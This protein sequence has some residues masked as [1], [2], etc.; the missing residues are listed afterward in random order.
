MNFMNAIDIGAS[1]LSAQR[2]HLNVVS[3]NLA[4]ASTTRTVTGG[5]Y[6][7]KVVTMKAAELTPFSSVMGTRLERELRGV[8]VNAVVN[9][10]GPLRKVYDPTH[11]D[12]DKS[13]YVSYP[14]INAVQEMANLMS[15]LRIY[16]ANV[17]S[18]ST[19]KNM[20]NKATEI[21]RG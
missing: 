18:I 1:G 14:N 11:P 6:H 5:P 20:F 15:V 12:A 7:K 3:M 9:D 10:P 16:E 21:G 19:A 17:N 2:T 4:N 13:G 8:K